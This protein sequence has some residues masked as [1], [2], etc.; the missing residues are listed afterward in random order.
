MSQLTPQFFQTILKMEG[1]YQKMPDDNGNYSCGALVGTNMGVSGVA[2]TDWYGRC[3]SE[4][5][6]RGLDQHTAFEFYAWYFDKYNLYH[7]QDQKFAEFLMNNT[8]GSPA[9]AARAEQKALN[10]LGYSV[11]VDGQRGPQTIQAL[12]DAWKKN[13][14][15]IY[16]AVRGEWI[17]HLESINKPQFLDGWMIRLNKWFP[18]LST[19]G[20]SLGSA[21]LILLAF[22]GWK[23]YKA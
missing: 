1:D 2:L 7:V 8:M 14:A 20:A 22:L 9:G 3:V 10:R 17:K 19:T 5:E 18:P 12:N 21:L 13:P 6:V 11:S 15:G 23:L 4:D 16:N